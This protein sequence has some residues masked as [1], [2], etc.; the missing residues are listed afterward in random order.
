MQ[1]FGHGE[2]SSKQRTVLLLQML[3]DSIETVS[4]QLST[5]RRRGLRSAQT[6]EAAILCAYDSFKGAATGDNPWEFGIGVLPQTDTTSIRCARS[7]VHAYGYSGAVG[8]NV[9][10]PGN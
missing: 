6:P 3:K 5:R 10:P 9:G 8:Q 1:M 7:C 4:E 2:P